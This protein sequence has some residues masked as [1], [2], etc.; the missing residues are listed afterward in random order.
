MNRLVAP[1]DG[2]FSGEM[3]FTYVR[4]QSSNVSGRKLT[5]PAQRLASSER[6]ESS[7]FEWL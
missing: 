5:A 1:A 3:F 6:D 4:C 7:H 2:A